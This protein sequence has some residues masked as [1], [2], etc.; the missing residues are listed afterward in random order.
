VNCVLSTVA[1]DNPG[2]V[3]TAVVAVAIGEELGCVVETTGTNKNPDELI[4]EAKFMVNYMMDKRGVEIKEMIV[5]PSTTTVK[6]I[7]SVVSSVVYMR[8]DIIQK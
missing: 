3:I 7:A 5:E 8:D 4:N 2:D 1:S 6:D